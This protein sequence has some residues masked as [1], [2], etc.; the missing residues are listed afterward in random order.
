MTE[1]DAWVVCVAIV[2]ITVLVLTWRLWAK[3]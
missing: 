1:A 2:C 3:P